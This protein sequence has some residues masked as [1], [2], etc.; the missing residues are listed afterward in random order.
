MEVKYQAL[1][2]SRFSVFKD[3]IFGSSN[4][5][6]NEGMFHIAILTLYMVIRQN[7]DY[8]VQL[9]HYLYTMA[10]LYIVINS[11]LFS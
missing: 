5:S 9:I 2:F 1:V 7:D 10:V 11:R 4:L 3:V 6:Q 8:F